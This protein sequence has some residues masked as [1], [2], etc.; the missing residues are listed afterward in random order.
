[1]DRAKVKKLII[2]LIAIFI[3]IYVAYVFISSVFDVD[4]VDTEIATEMTATHS[5]HKDGIIVRD[6]KLIKSD[7]EGVISYVCRDGDSVA[8]NQEVAQVYESEEDALSNQEIDSIDSEIAR[9]K[10]LNATASNGD[11][12][13]DTIDSQINNAIKD[14][15]INIA[16][17]DFLNTN[18]YINNLTYLV[19]ERMFVTGKT[20]DIASR[21][22]ELE[23]EKEEL[24]SQTNKAV[25]E[26]KTPSP[27]CFASSADGYETVYDYDN[28]KSTNL[29]QYN[30][31][32]KAKPKKISDDTVGKVITSTN[33]YIVC[34]ITKEEAL[35]LTTN[36]YE[37]ITVNMPYAS[38]SS[39]P[40]TIEAINKDS[41]GGDCILVIKCDYMN[42]E[43]ATIRNENIEICLNTYQGIRVSKSALHDDEVKKTT[44]DENGNVKTEKKKVQGVYVMYGNEL[45]FKEVSIIYSGSDFVICDPSPDSDKLFNGETITLYDNI[46]VNGSDLKDGKV[47]N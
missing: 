24:K 9:I 7:N 32:K 8:K 34:P 1:M 22:T 23:A 37:T 21:L 43:L 38:T 47:I 42:S 39:I 26:I 35:S 12:G 10:K 4:G 25:A 14:F 29:S 28:V 20:V 40:V 6:E 18:T 13:I 31:M 2:A 30:K 11:L 5:L 17:R 46:V 36:T 41:N 44:E 45:Q 27:G 15:N 33:W 19:T 16:D 3:I